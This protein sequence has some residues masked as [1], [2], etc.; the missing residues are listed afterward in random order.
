MEIKLGGKRGGV[1]LVS[2]EDYE[3]VNQYSWSQDKGG[4][5]RGKANGKMIGLS[6]FIMKPTEREIVDHINQIRTDNRRENLRVTVTALNNG[7]KSKAAG[8]SS[9][10]RNIHFNKKENQFRAQISIG[11]KTTSL[12][13]FKDEI[14]AAEAVDKYIV[15]NKLDYI[16]LNF[17]EKREAYLKEE[18]V[19]PEKLI[20]T[21]KY[22][23]TRTKGKRFVC[24]F[25]SNGKQIYI[26]TFDSELECANKYDEYITTHNIPNR[27]LNFPEKYSDYNPRVIKMQGKIYDDNTIQLIIPGDDRIVLIDRDDY[28][29]VKYFK[30]H[31]EKK[32]GYVKISKDRNCICI[33]R[34]LMG[35]T[36]P[37]IFVDHIDSN[38]LNNRRSNLRMSNAG[39][40]GQNKSKRNAENV[41][42]K[43]IGVHFCNTYKFYIAKIS[44]CGKNVLYIQNR[45]ELMVAKIRD[46]FILSKL[47]ND[48]YKLNFKWNDKEIKIWK[49]YYN[50]IKF[51]QKK[52]L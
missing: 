9:K 18:Y 2:K 35:A 26:G 49:T 6:R 4:Y 39:L 23:G 44:K 31:I 24:T 38:P 36:D 28:E 19:A 20:R 12:G 41:S 21:N 42:S 27:K 3:N 46:L 8:K 51:N 52:L 14:K 17:P 33:H 7:N 22:E 10:Y 48:H 34:F 50:I 30:T 29:I 5:V 32:Q 13:A 11:G 45:N 15:H 16:H 37:L 43:Y 40:N 1:A 25:S 47:Q